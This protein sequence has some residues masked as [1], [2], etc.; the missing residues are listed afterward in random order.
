MAIVLSLKIVQVDDHPRKFPQLAA[1]MDADTSFLIYREF[2]YLRNRLLLD[3]EIELAQLERDLM[4]QDDEYARTCPGALVTRN[5]EKVCD[6][7]STQNSRLLMDLIY[8]KLTE[9]GQWQNPQG[10]VLVL[11]STYR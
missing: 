3:R 1:L 2:S 4:T 8:K 10:Q 7:P 5:L 9:Y 11:T 6:E